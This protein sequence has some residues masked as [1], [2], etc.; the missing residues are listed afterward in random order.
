MY[1]W[2]IYNRLVDFLNKNNMLCKYQYGFRTGKSTET[3]AVKLVQF[4]HQ[5]LD[6]EHTVAGMFD[7]S[8]AFNT[9]NFSLVE[10]K[11]YRIGLRGN[12]L[13]LT[14]L[15]VSEQKTM[16]TI[17]SY[18]PDQYDINMGTPQGSVLAWLIFI[19]SVINDLQLPGAVQEMSVKIW[20]N[21]VHQTIY[22]QLKKICDSSLY[23]NNPK[24]DINNGWE[25]VNF[26]E[27]IL[28][29]KN[30]WDQQIDHICLG[31]N[32]ATTKLK[33]TIVKITWYMYTMP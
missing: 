19:H 15:F 33:Q 28:S 26:L 6:S 10:Q 30:R 9:L 29:S 22:C 5:E 13:S 3:A 16:V 32:K 7:L 2:A 23:N 31:L 20:I 12:T 11:L 24:V 18:N 27:I 21:D 14:M 25:V 17:N 4:I 8:K 1:E